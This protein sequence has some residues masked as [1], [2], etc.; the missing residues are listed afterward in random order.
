MLNSSGPFWEPEYF[1]HLIRNEEEFHRYI[2]YV[3]SNPVKAG[4]QNWKWVW[5]E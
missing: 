1:D 5:A 4:L 3:V 2:E